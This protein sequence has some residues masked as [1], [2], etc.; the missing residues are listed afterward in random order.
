MI[1]VQ[2]APLMEKQRRDVLIKQYMKREGI[3]P[4]IKIPV[5]VIM[6]LKLAYPMPRAK[7]RDIARK[8]NMDWDLYRLL[9]KEVA[10]RIKAGV[11]L[12]TGLPKIEEEKNEGKNITN[13]S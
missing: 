7:R 13:S 9:E 10:K 1:N 6:E 12:E 3:N 8:A 11:S 5:S 2:D 4:D